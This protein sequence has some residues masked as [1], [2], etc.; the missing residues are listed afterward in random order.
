MPRVASPRTEG[1][2]NTPQPSLGA[3]L[4]VVSHDLLEQIARS[5]LAECFGDGL[6]G[7]LAGQGLVLCVLDLPEWFPGAISEDGAVTVRRALDPATRARVA[8]RLLARWTLRDLPH[9]P[10]DVEQLAGAIDRLMS[11]S[12][13]AC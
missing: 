12:S 1:L 9:T 3:P 10:G 13:I 8:L 5:I 11:I 6:S 4:P 7:L 2:Q